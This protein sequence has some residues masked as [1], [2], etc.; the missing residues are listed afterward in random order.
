MNLCCACRRDFAGLGPFDEHQSWNYRAKPPKLTCK[1][2]ATLGMELNKYNRWGRPG[3]IKTREYVPAAERP[4][5]DYERD[6]TVCGAV[7][8]RPRTRGRP[9][10]K[11]EQCR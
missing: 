4:S 6:C 7:F 10:T 9:P 1:D 3:D 2:P 5:S 11:C 8:E